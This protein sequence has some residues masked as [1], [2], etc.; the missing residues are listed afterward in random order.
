MPKVTETV[1]VPDCKADKRGLKYNGTTSNTKSGLTCQ[2]WDSQ[3]PHIHVNFHHYK[4]N[5]CRN[6]AGEGDEPW[7]Y[8]TSIWKRWEYCEIPICG[9][10]FQCLHVHCS[11]VGSRRFKLRKGPPYP[12]S[13]K[14]TEMGRFLGIPFKR[15]MD[16][17]VE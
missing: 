1:K 2:R 4:E 6:E 8:T 10:S 7:C 5:Y 11:S 14:A 12:A 3:F 16:G 13:E 9:M 17:H 15:C